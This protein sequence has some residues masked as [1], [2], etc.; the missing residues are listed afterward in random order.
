MA[1]KPAGKTDKTGKVA[2]VAPIPAPFDKGQKTV[3][4]GR[5]ATQFKPG[6]AG[7]PGRPLGA[8]SKLSEDFLS[9]LYADWQKGGAAAIAAV[10]ETDPVAYVKVVA[11]VIPREDKLEATIKRD[12]DELSDAELVGLINRNRSLINGL[13]Q[14]PNGSGKLN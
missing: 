1:K 4:S 12:I 2:P 10:R 14:A 13:T 7:G 6:N 3:G 8:R 9:A 11:S 5:E